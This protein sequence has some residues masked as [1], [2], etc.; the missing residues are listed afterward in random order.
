LEYFK[1]VHENKTY[2]FVN[3]WRELGKCHKVE[4]GYALYKKNLENGGGNALMA[5]DLEDEGPSN[6]VLP[7]HPRNHKSSV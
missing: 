3:C 4:L 7:S 1:T 5:I 6:V 2:N